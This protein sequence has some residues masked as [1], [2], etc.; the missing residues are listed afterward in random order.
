M[1]K[2]KPM[3]KPM[4]DAPPPEAAPAPASPEAVRIAALEAALA[5]AMR[6]N[7]ELRAQ[8]EAL[9]PA[10]P[11]VEVEMEDSL[12]PAVQDS[13]AAKRIKL[14]AGVRSV[15]GDETRTDGVSSAD[16]R[17]AVVTKAFPSV[18]L[19]GLDTRAVA[20]LADAA[21]DAA[22]TSSRTLALASAHPGAPRAD[23]LSDTDPADALRRRT[24]SA[25]TARKDH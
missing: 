15:C 9:K 21:L 8:L 19:D 17:R 24:S 11:E 18:K 13:I 4:M 6:S 5:D 22:S 1:P 7:A 23:S 25:W 12:P 16:L 20:A 10:S 3:D 2:D 14:L